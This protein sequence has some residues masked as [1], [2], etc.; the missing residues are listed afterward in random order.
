[1]PISPEER[2]LLRDLARR[3]ADV[4]DLPIMAQRR[5][6]WKKHNSLQR[7]R[8]MVLIFP[9]GSWGELLP[10]SELKCSDPHARSIE[11]TL[12]SRLYYHEHL[13]DDTV[14]EK[15]WIVPKVTHRT[16]WG[17]S[18][19][20]VPSTT[21]RGAWAFDPVIHEPADLKKLTF[22][23]VTYD[24]PATMQA[25]EQARD[26]LGDILNIRLKGVS[27]V[28]FHLFNIYC[29]LRGLEQVFWDMSENPNM[30][31]DAMAFLEEGHHNLIRQYVDQ[32]LLSLNNDATYHSTG[33]N[34]YTDELPL[35]D[36]DPERIRP[37]DMWASA[38]AQELDPVSPEMH[39]EFSLQY[40]R[41][42][43]APFALNGYG[44]CDDLVKKLD[45]VFQIPGIRRIS[46]AP[47][48]DVDEAA[49]RLGPNYIFSWKPKP[50]FL[51]GSFDPEK[52]RADIRH[53]LDVS[54]DCVVEMVLKDTHTCEHHPER[55]WEWTRIAK[56][57]AEEY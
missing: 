29:D 17:M 16:G 44:C 2:T 31:H 8:P 34:G 32:N 45:Y 3:V 33:G 18:G 48:A 28:S 23:V 26:L 4:A 35:S 41:R 22:P 53:T 6:M 37:C 30:L 49:E 1:M 36:Y 51:V 11:W 13:D 27:H 14:I 10:Q 57:L 21:A 38:E 43:L 20:R 7:V 25:L 56:E 19:K 47:F 46:I 54:R 24:E 5:E 39:E 42:L 15:E 55:F 9:E 52:V 12:R 40:E 50:A